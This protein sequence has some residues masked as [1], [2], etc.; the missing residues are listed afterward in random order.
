MWYNSSVEVWWLYKTCHVTPHYTHPQSHMK[1]KLIFWALWS[2]V[3]MKY[4]KMQAKNTICLTFLKGQTFFVV[5]TKLKNVFYLRK[6]LSSLR[7]F[8]SFSMSGI[9]ASSD[10]TVFTMATSCS[11]RVRHLSSSCQ[12]MTKEISKSTT[13]CLLCGWQK[14]SVLS[15]YFWGWN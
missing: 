9:F 8:S 2:C 6:V 7:C 10:L 4:L 13:M 5:T 15:R 14:S 12:T 1:W 3:R 11:C